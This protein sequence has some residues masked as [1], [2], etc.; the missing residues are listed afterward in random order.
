MCA[1]LLEPL[2]PF[3]VGATAA[4]VQ[5]PVHDALDAIS[6]RSWLNSPWS[7]S[8]ADELYKAANIL[9]KFNDVRCVPVF[10]LNAFSGDV[11]CKAANILRRFNE[12]GDRRWLCAWCNSLFVCLLW[13][14]IL[15][16]WCGTC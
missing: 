11:L 10:C 12:V 1:S 4:S 13:R 5:P 6:L 3:L 15:Y 8:M 16:A 14:F 2:Q 9:R 7:G